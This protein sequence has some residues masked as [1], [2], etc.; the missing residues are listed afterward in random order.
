[1]QPG[2]QH[3]AVLLEGG[4]WGGWTYCTIQDTEQQIQ[5]TMSSSNGPE[6]NLL[7]LRKRKPWTF[8]GSQGVTFHT[9]LATVS[10]TMAMQPTTNSLTSVII[11]K[12]CSLYHHK[13][14]PFIHDLSQSA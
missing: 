13:A 8:S 14:Y 11:E 3:M 6:D 1:M 9:K 7:V 12:T 5:S 2:L 10:G 4:G